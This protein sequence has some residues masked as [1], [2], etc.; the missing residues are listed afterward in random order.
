MMISQ[1]E[2]EE[3]IPSDLSDARQ[4][5]ARLMVVDVRDVSKLEFY[6]LNRPE[7]V[8]GNA[9][10]VN[11]STSPELLLKE[12]LAALDER[13]RSQTEQMSSRIE[14]ERSEAKA[15]GRREWE[16][17]LEERI[18]EERAVVFKIV[19]EFHDQ[20]SKYFAEV[21][22]EVVKLA[23][24]V[25]KR[26]LHREAQLDPLLLTGVVRVALEKLAQDSTAVLRVPTKELQTWHQVFVENHN[27]SFELLADERLGS[28]EC[29]LDTNVGKIELGVSAQLQEIER[30]FFDLMQRRPA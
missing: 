9:K 4:T 22:G 17:E 13:L 26:V 24:A 2:N 12:E 30:G 8:D 18:A 6:P 27:S 10:L 16:L 14:M 3:A 23:L 7:N 25:A 20:R 21:E 11:E 28:G 19:E 29:V 5:P 1:F 15:E